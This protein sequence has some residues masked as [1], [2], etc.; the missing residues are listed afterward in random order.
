CAAAFETAT[1][2]WEATPTATKAE[3]KPARRFR[4][5]AIF[6]LGSFRV[7]IG[8]SIGLGLFLIATLR[9]FLF[10]PA[11][12]KAHR[13]GPLKPPISGRIQPAVVDRLRIRSLDIHHV[14][15]AND[16][17]V[18]ARGRLGHET[19]TA[20]TNDDIRVTAELSRRAYSY[21]IIFRADG[22][23]EVLYPQGA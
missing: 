12:Q 20:T 13:V 1:T 3:K 15:E 18:Q 23:D 2:E 19:Y 22:K 5:G 6:G 11:I 10:H 16:G 4:L 7:R 14:E 8:I 9:L 21:I 17:K